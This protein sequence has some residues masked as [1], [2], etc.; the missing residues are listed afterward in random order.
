MYLCLSLGFMGRYR[1]AR[2]EGELDEVRATVHTI[3]AA[4]RHGTRE[5]LSRRWQGVAAPYQPHKG[6]V[7][8]WV[9]FAGA[10]A[11]CGGLLFWASTS[12]NAAS[13]TLQAQALGTPPTHMPL[14]TRAA[15]VQPVPPPPPPP[16]PTALDRLR[17]SLQPEIDR[18]AI[19]LLGTPATPIIR[20][21]DRGVFA[22][23]SAAVQSG[24]VSLLER[25]AAALRA[26]PGALRVIDHTD[27]QPVRTVQFPSNFQLSTARANAVRVIVARGVGDAG[28]VSAEGRADADPLVPNTSAE[29]RELNRRIEIVLHRQ[30]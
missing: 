26:E 1:Q 6:G 21:S 8:V 4:Q 10:V 2:G 23:G 12:L 14:V 24:A 9:A 19:T 11:T 5:D 7:P 3:I 29:E 30:A 27:N 17:A 20:L 15:I 28:R 25:I 22:A 13:D 18:G 16:E